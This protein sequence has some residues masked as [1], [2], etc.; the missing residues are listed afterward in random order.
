MILIE[1]WK[2]EKKRFRIVY[3]IENQ[4]LLSHQSR[5]VNST[6]PIVVK[7]EIENKQKWKKYVSPIRFSNVTRGD[8]T[9][10]WRRFF[11]SSDILKNYICVNKRHK[12]YLQ[13]FKT[14]KNPNLQKLK[15]AKMTF[16]IIKSLQVQMLK[17]VT[18]I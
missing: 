16:P 17:N 12:N 4:D 9:F 1:W 8:K 6:G 3:I 2:E 18:R 10:L 11:S 7:G 13:I 14:C 15:F 5:E